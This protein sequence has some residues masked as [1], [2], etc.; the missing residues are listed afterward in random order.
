[1]PR[2][3]GSNCRYVSVQLLNHE[4]AALDEA[5]KVAGMTR[6]RFI[7]SWIAAGCPVAS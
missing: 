3:R 1:M 5:A 6:N 7:R 4:V 2:P